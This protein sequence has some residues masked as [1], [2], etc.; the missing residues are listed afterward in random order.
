MKK[1]RKISTNQVNASPPPA[2][3]RRVDPPLNQLRA[4][5]PSTDD[6]L[7]WRCP[8]KPDHKRLQNMRVV[9]SVCIALRRDVSLGSI[10]CLR[11]MQC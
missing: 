7:S 9:A 2:G 5:V 1:G 4:I 11:G 8:T 10:R 3:L 6:S